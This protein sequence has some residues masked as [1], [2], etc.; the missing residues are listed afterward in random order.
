MEEG[1]YHESDDEKYVISSDDDD[2]P[3][4][5]PIC[6]KVFAVPIVT[7]C[8]HYFCEKCAIG[9]ISKVT[10]RQTRSDKPKLIFLQKTTKNLKDAKFVGSKRTECLTQQKT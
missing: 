3:Q 10:F 6:R 4:K 2:L 7:R 1:T 8:K 9:E 5:C